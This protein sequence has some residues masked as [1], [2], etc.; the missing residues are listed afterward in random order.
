[1]DTYLEEM[2]TYMEHM[3]AG[4]SDWN[5]EALAGAGPAVCKST[6]TF[7][8]LLPKNLQV[9]QQKKNENLLHTLEQNQTS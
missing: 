8:R 2:S 3:A 9:Y 7:P 1:M 4:L 5:R 6:F